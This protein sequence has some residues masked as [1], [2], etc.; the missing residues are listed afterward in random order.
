MS[1]A[2]A[3]CMACD[4][5]SGKQPLPGGVIHR[6][7]F[8]TVEHCIGPLGVGTLILKPLRH[9]TRFAELTADEAAEFGPLLH[10]VA[11]A[12]MAELSPDQ[13]YVTEWSHAGWEPGH[14]HFVVQPAW[15]S[16]RKQ[17]ARPGPAMQMDMFTANV[18]PDQDEVAAF[19]DKIR[20]RFEANPPDSTQ[21]K[22][23]VQQ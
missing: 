9:V 7:R 1:G 4:L 16:Q 23:A 11:Q 19:C 18:T 20:T 5:T 22:R 12:L 15:D 6:S 10:Y 17:Y 3:S 13:T 21:R 8:W 14:I 2:A